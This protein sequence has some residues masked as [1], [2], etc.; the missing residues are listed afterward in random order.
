MKPTTV[1][2]QNPGFR[3]ALAVVATGLL[4][5]PVLLAPTTQPAFSK[6]VIVLDVDVKAVARGYRVSELTGANV[7]NAKAE[8][9][10]AIDDLI[11]DREK[12]L[13]AIVQVG[14]FLGLGGYL[15]AVP[16][17]ALEI[18]EDGSK[19]VL[20]QGSKEELQKLPEFRY[21]QD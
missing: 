14:G 9:I 18:N 4:V 11:V 1:S 2:D 16:Y 8:K 12:V 15:V 13:F 6:N 5:S 21:D 7:E 10:G 17:N 20:A 19:I 3:L